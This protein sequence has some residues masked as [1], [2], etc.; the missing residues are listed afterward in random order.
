MFLLSFLSFWSIN[1]FVVGVVIIIIGGFFLVF[2][3]LIVFLIK[4]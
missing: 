3:V 2:F 4:K 1:L